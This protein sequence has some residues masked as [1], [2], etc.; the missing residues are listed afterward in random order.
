MIVL[1]WFF[2]KIYD[3]EAIK[4]FM[5]HYKETT[6]LAIE[7]FRLSQRKFFIKKLDVYIDLWKSFSCNFVKSIEN[8][9]FL[10]ILYIYDKIVFR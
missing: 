9:H 8:A 7:Y 4:W 2:I 10:F 5:H 6:D 1:D 3:I